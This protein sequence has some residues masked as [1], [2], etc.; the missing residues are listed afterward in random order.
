VRKN[1]ELRYARYLERIDKWVDDH[2]CFR[3]LPTEEDYVPGR[4]STPLQAVMSDDALMGLHDDETYLA[5][6]VSRLEESSDENLFAAIGALGL[7]KTTTAN[8]LR[9]RVAKRNSKVEGFPESVWEP[10]LVDFLP[11]H[12]RDHR[13]EDLGQRVRTKL[14][15]NIIDDWWATGKMPT[16]IG[17]AMRAIV[18]YLLL[19][20]PIEAWATASDQHRYPVPTGDDPISDVDVPSV[21]DSPPTPEL[22]DLLQTRFG[23]R[24]RR[25]RKYVKRLSET[26]E[27]NADLAASVIGFYLERYRVDDAL[28]VIIVDNVDQLPSDDIAEIVH[29][30]YSLARRNE[31]MRFL[32]SM[33]PGSWAGLGGAVDHLTGVPHC[34]PCRYELVYQR[35][36]RHVLGR[37]RHVLM[38][39]RSRAS[40]YMA[41]DGRPAVFDGPVSEEVNALLITSFV[42]ARLMLAG[43]SGEKSVGAD[44]DALAH[45]HED[46][47]P[48][49]SRLQAHGNSLCRA[50]NTLGALVGLSG[51][52]AVAHLSQFFNDFYGK[53]AF[54]ADACRRLGDP[55]RTVVQIP[56]R[57]LIEGVLFDS[58]SYH[59]RLGHAINLFR[60]VKRIRN[61]QWPSLVFLRTLT[62]LEQI[63]GAVYARHVVDHLADFGIPS[64]IAVK[65][66]NA[67]HDRRRRLVWF[68]RS[69]E[70]IHG[71]LG[72]AR[73]VLSECGKMYLKHIIGD[74]D[75][76]W[77][78]AAAITHSRPSTTNFPERLRLFVG[79]VRD[80]AHVEWKQNA[81]RMSSSSEPIPVDGH[82]GTEP[83]LSLRVLY[84]SAAQAAP[85]G[86]GALQR[87]RRRP[88]QP[89]DD[90]YIR[91]LGEYIGALARLIVEC[92][93]R[94]AACFGHDGYVGVYEMAIRQA[95][96]TF[97]GVERRL[98]SRL[99]EYDTQ[100]IRQMIERW[101]ARLTNLDAIKNQ[102]AA[103]PAAPRHAVARAAELARGFLP[104]SLEA[105]DNA[106]AKRLKLTAYRAEV[107]RVTEALSRRLPHYGEL[108]SAA[109]NLRDNAEHLVKTATSAGAAAGAELIAWANTEHAWWSSRAEELAAHA[110]ITTGDLHD[111]VTTN[112]RKD[113]FNSLLAVYHN[114]LVHLGVASAYRIK[115]AGWSY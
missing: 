104:V 14:L 48:M 109:N 95:L 41:S 5:T 31:A 105:I 113:R 64:E 47:K 52:H 77:A 11:D 55:G 7:G 29:Q 66:M 69:H 25:L 6:L 38:E 26:A 51:R 54:L 84:S 35:L 101:Q 2:L 53:P 97:L 78:C 67:L 34:G 27:D 81:F 4:H 10:V 21:L 89:S 102:P 12:G 72:D 80:A 85:V 46:H 90:E 62:F 112:D 110:Y 39:S 98:G 96:T 71:K 83:S 91:D 19:L 115:E 30:L 88:D 73:V 60:P 16:P 45:V 22:L 82:C 75:Y 100:S 20:D 76:L 36:C 3:S 61:T 79:L 49:L 28:H 57:R 32:I 8:F 70:L 24:R 99:M 63:D 17:N 9:R 87:A 43:M 65:A 74:F 94:Y 44:F 86:A 15:N 92:E 93:D 18:Q 33:R 40:R 37:P 56:Y 50:A 42:Y 106:E 68:T 107:G 59:E 58:A 114:V 23:N 103:A 111:Y 13:T 108:L 1:T